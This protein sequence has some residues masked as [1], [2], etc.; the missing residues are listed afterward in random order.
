MIV[1]PNRSTWEVFNHDLNKP[2][3]RPVYHAVINLSTIC[4]REA[5]KE[6]KKSG[7][8]T[9]YETRKE[10]PLDDPRITSRVK[11]VSGVSK[12]IWE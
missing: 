8:K 4:D 2:K 7:K 10:E 5:S 6:T 3:E 1:K 12:P 9:Q 11:A